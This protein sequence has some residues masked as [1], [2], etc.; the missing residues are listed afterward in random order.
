MRVQPILN[1]GEQFYWVSESDDWILSEQF[2]EPHFHVDLSLMGFSECFTKSGPL[3][4]TSRETASRL[5][6]AKIDGAQVD[7][8]TYVQIIAVRPLD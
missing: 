3:A 4:V 7:V 8:P 2:S 5:S 6:S 1:S